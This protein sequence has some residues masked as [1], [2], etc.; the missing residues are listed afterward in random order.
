MGLPGRVTLPQARMIAQAGPVTWTPCSGYVVVIGYASP[1]G[2][3]DG[4]AGSIDGYA[5][6]G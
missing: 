2:A 3:V 4:Y 5:P 6:M 1:N